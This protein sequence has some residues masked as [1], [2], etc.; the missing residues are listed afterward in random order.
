MK[1][2]DQ[3]LWDWYTANGCISWLVSV[4]H[5]LERLEWV[6]LMDGNREILRWQHV[7]KATTEGRW[8]RDRLQRLWQNEMRGQFQEGYSEVNEI[9]VVLIQ[10]LWCLFKR[11]FWDIFWI[12]ALIIDYKHCRSLGHFWFEALNWLDHVKLLMAHFTAPSV[13]FLLLLNDLSLQWWPYGKPVSCQTPLW[14][15]FHQQIQPLPQKD[16]SQEM[17]DCHA[18]GKEEVTTIWIDSR[19]IK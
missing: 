3:Q 14:C 9:V 10:W 13:D 1:R 5:G 6:V 12:K 19:K 17:A 16:G 7:V 15:C 8:E 4:S 2:T 18:A 11:V